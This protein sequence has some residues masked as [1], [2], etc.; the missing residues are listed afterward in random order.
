MQILDFSEVTFFDNHVFTRNKGHNGG[1][2]SIFDGDIFIGFENAT[3]VF[4]SN[5]AENLGGGLYMA[6]DPSQSSTCNLHIASM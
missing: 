3:V 6:E 4:E 5:Y 1:G 2:I